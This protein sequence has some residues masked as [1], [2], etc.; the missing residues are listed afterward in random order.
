VRAF[1][2]RHEYAVI[3]VVSGIVYI[4]VGVFVRGLL[5]WIIGPIWPIVCMWF[6]PVLVRRIGGWSDPLPSERATTEG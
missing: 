6:V 3:Y 5:N 2:L 1:Y 4:V